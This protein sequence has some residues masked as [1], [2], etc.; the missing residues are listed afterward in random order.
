MLGYLKIILI[1]FIICVS[2]VALLGIFNWILHLKYFH[3]PAEKL[4]VIESIHFFCSV[5]LLIIFPLFTIVE[6]IAKKVEEIKTR[7]GDTGND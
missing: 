4:A 3:L 5:I 2:I 1:D 6:I 7:N